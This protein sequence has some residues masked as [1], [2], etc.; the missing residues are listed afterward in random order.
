MRADVRLIWSRES[1]N[2]LVNQ[3]HVQTGGIIAIMCS[4]IGIARELE[5][6]FDTCRLLWQYFLISLL[7]GS[8][9]NNQQT[10]LEFNGLMR[11]N[12]AIPI[13]IY[14]SF[15]CL[16]D[17]IEQ[18]LVGQSEFLWALIAVQLNVIS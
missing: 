1:R 15:N 17:A 16:T 7:W 5:P 14:A 18:C 3:L 4:E 11:S 2:D 9:Y 10:K 12:L 8:I 13:Y 6:F